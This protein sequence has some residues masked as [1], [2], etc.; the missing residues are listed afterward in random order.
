MNAWPA[1][2]VAH[3]VSFSPKARDDLRQLYL[4]IAERAGE[5]R[6]LAYLERIQQYCL[7]FSTFPERGTLRDDLLPGLR[8]IG[9][10]RR[11]TLAFH[12]DASTVTF[13]RFL[14]GGRDLGLLSD[15]E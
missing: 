10:E 7:G 13:D 4:Y 11:V 2:T 12:V 3:R 14:Y 6:A 9:F 1:W 8:I 5:R 15:G